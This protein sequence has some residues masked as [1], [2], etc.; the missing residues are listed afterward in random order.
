MRRTLYRIGIL[1]AAGV[2]LGSTAVRAHDDDHERG[3]WF[4][5][6]SISIGHRMGPAFTGANFAP[7][8]SNTALRMVVRPS[9]SGGAVRVRIENT[10]ALTA[11]T[12]SGAFVGELGSGAALVP[13]TNRR[14]TFN[15]H[16]G[17]SLAAGASAWSDPVR[18]HVEAFRRLAVSLDVVSA[19]EISGHQLGLT[20]N[21]VGS[22]GSAGSA[23]GDGFAPVPPNSG[24][25]PFY[26]VAAVDVRSATASG[27]I[28][29]LGDSITDGRCSTRDPATGNIPADEYNRWPDVLAARLHALYGR[30]APAV[31]NESI[32]GNRVV[33]PGG[34]GPAAVL[35]LQNDVLDRAGL[36][37]V[38]F[39]E[40]TND[41]TGGATSAQ[42]IAGLQEVVDRVH[43]KGVPIYGG[44]VV[45]RGRPAPLTGWTGP[46]EAVKLAANH[47]LHTEA[48]F[49]GI[50]EFGALLA[51]PIVI[52]ADGAPAESLWDAWNCFDYTHPNK[53]GLAEMGS[54]IDLDLFKPARRDR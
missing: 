6:W 19:V 44:T 2:L 42:L 22:F 18:F 5:A 53:F 30:R 35:R 50:V 12:F 52:G 51:G 16:P 49:D 28:V 29:T 14:L 54:L 45:P 40:G 25:Y 20:T 38:I 4:T 43:A 8:V 36:R 24:N 31:S 9:I 1:A 3:N 7:D 47:W 17:L 15:G 34:N 48:N 26:Y 21:Y 23:S 33:L 27:T 37:W 13:G 11:V 39:Y 32:A 10:Q 41:I 46:M